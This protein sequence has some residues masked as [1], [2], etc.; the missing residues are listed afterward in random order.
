M[1]QIGPVYDIYAG[2]HPAL[3]SGKLLDSPW[4]KGAQALSPIGLVCV[5]VDN[6][7]KLW[8]TL[9]FKDLTSQIIQSP[10]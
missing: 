3:Y 8:K 1:L 6:I 5:K 4:G 9:N 2:N 10:P 7:Q